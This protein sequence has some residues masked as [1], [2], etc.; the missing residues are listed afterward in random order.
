[1]F[2]P[3]EGC[4][5]GSDLHTR[6]ELPASEQKQDRETARW[7]TQPSDW[8]ET[9]LKR[10]LAQ[11]TER[12]AVLCWLKTNKQTNTGSRCSRESRGCSATGWNYRFKVT[13]E[14]THKKR[15]FCQKQQ[16]PHH[17]STPQT[18]IQPPHPTL[19]PTPGTSSDGPRSK[20]MELSGEEDQATDKRKSRG[21]LAGQIHSSNKYP[22]SACVR[23]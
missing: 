21:I 22:L 10:E 23:L 7:I 18:P 20:S 2:L 15:D 12:K 14:K 16:L 4:Q 13:C 5:A 11:K 9:G 1:M 6:Q 8:G 17:S 3:N 19:T